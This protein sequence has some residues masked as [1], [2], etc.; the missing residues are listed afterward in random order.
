M[1]SFEH[2]KSWADIWGRG[3]PHWNS[4]CPVS[5]SQLGFIVCVDSTHAGK[6]VSTLNPSTCHMVRGQAWLLWTRH[7]PCLLGRYRQHML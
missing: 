6:A 3:P 4:Q 1:P 2:A 5:G 7:S